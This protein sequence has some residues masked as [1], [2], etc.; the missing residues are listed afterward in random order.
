MQQSTS[1]HGHAV[2][3][4]SLGADCRELCSAGYGRVVQLLHKQL[5]RL[6]A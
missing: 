5:L 1:L 4:G 2:L 3:T 6:F